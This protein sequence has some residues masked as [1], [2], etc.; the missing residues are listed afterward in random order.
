MSSSRKP[1]IAVAGLALLALSACTS[2]PLYGTTSVDPA[3]GARSSVLTEL[4]G[5]IAVQPAPTRSAQ[6][7]RNAMLYRL[8]GAE[9]VRDPL[10]ELRY[11]VT[12]TDSVVSVEEGTGV[13]SASLFRT[14]VSYTLVRVSDQ[15][16]VATGS[17]F[18]MAPYDRSNQ[19]FAASRAVIDARRQASETVA[20]R[21]LYAITPV[22]QREAFQPAAQGAV[23]K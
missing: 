22:L 15:K 19:L 23:T 3:T 13:P 4:R 16:P 12:G 17:R 11:T 5:R 7:F 18:A 6:I 21:I 20:D 1:F 10:Y 8:N 2:G 14:N 9:P